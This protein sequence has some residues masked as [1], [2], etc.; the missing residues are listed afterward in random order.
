MWCEA[1]TTPGRMPSVRQARMTNQPSRVLTRTRPSTSISSFSASLGWIQRGW[2]WLISLSHF[3]LPPRVWIIVGSRN[4]GI[5]MRSPA[6]KSRSSQWTW[7]GIQVGS[8]YSGQPQ[9]RSI[10]EYS[11]SFHEGVG[12]PARTTPSISTPREPSP[13]NGMWPPMSSRSSWRPAVPGTR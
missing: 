1:P 6:P 11:S 10:S 13:M 3:E 12:K 5:R 4:V 8:A 9:S 2:P 7:D